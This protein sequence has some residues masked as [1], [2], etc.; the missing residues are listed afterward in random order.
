MT[1]TVC[2]K[3]SF[4]SLNPTPF[5]DSTHALFFDR[6]KYHQTTG[7]FCDVTISV[8]STT[9][10]A[11][12]VV[13]ASVSPYFDSLLRFNR[14]TK[15][16]ICLR[17]GNA[18][19]FESLL[20]YM[21]SGQIT[22]DRSNV[23]DLFKYS[24]ELMI[25]R[26]KSYC[27][28]YLQ[29]YLDTANCLA[30][31]S[32][33]EKYEI[34][35]LVVKATKF[36]EENLNSVLEENP[37][38]LEWNETELFDTISKYEES[39]SIKPDTY[40]S[41]I[42]RWINHRCEQRERYFESLFK[43]MVNIGELNIERV[44]QMIDF[45]PF[46]RQNEK[47]LF[48]V[49]NELRA[50][51]KLDSRYE[52]KYATL[53]EK[54]GNLVTENERDLSLMEE[55]AV[56][57]S[58]ES[59]LMTDVEAEEPQSV[60][61]NPSVDSERRPSLKLKISLKSV[62]AEAEK[63]CQIAKEKRKRGRPRKFPQR[64]LIQVNDQETEDRFFNFEESTEPVIYEEADDMNPEEANEA[65]E[66]DGESDHDELTCKYCPYEARSVA[67]MKKHVSVAHS[68]NVVYICNICK[69]ECKWNRLFYEHMREHFP[70]PPFKCDSCTYV[71]DRMHVLL[72]HRLTHTNEK[73]YKCPECEFQTRTKSNLI[74][75]HRLHSGEKPFKCSDC[76]KTFAIKS[77]LNQHKAVHLELRPFACDQCEFTTKYQSHLISH[78]RIHNGDLFRCQEPGCDYSSPKKSQLAAHLRTHLAVRPHHC[79]VCNRSFIERSHLVRHERIHLSDKPFKCVQCDYSSSR[80]DKLKEHVLKHHNAKVRSKHYRHNNRR[81]R[82][83]AELSAKA[84]QLPP[85]NQENTFRPIRSEN[86]QT[87]GGQRAQSGSAQSVPFD[88]NFAECQPQQ[89]HGIQRQHSVPIDAAMQLGTYQQTAPSLQQPTAVHLQHSAFNLVPQSSGLLD[90][91]QS[92]IG[93]NTY[94]NIPQY[95]PTG[96]AMPNIGSGMFDS[97]MLAG[98]SNRN[99]M[100][101]MDVSDQQSRLQQ[102]YL[103][104]DDMS[105]Y[106]DGMNAEV[107]QFEGEV[108][109]ASFVGQS[110]HLPMDTNIN[111]Q[112][113]DLQRPMSLPPPSNQQ[114]PLYQQLP[115][116]WWS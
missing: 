104:V 18:A 70:G 94:N 60:N 75:H 89:L 23:I 1:L 15:E 32:L 41:L 40:F 84:K 87:T 52:Q 103:P 114:T 111:L 80:R 93:P 77:T 58:E 43:N 19:S 88:F 86:F 90:R 74:V 69:Y 5:K 14:I 20:N 57:S 66:L 33:A 79:K 71:V 39:M 28:D 12:R 54:F 35:K 47:P 25:I 7:R 109:T 13:L 4:A 42:V 3:D 99:V 100:T 113:N 8:N 81:T 49:L 50:N 102:Q 85:T 106:S 110:H 68:R 46:F 34:T 72:S 38:V 95:A 78:R 82:E 48:V 11:H 45:N 36:F 44:E 53:H 83:L 37:D 16:K 59:S 22:I 29:R 63:L 56:H 62:G 115:N 64:S 55:D 105:V 51:N 6:L 30:V 21:Y 17:Y 108:A 24:N 96:S 101:A 10:R 67:R 73:P 26:L 107:G 91:P 27:V 97:L 61:P 112:Q 98:G 76:S 31:K 2:S 92:E 116:E 65:D 9:F